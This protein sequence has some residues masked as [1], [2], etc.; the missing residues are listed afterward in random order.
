[1]GSLTHC[2][3]INELQKPIAKK[4]RTKQKEYL[5]DG[6]T[7]AQA[8]QKAVADI[9]KI[10]KS[11]RSDIIEQV[12]K[13][14]EIDHPETLPREEH[15]GID[16][17]RKDLKEDIQQVDNQDKAAKVL[18]KLA[19]K[20]KKKIVFFKGSK[21]IKGSFDPTHPNT[22]F[23]NTATDK[24]MLFVFG[25]ELLHNLK[26]DD[27]ALYL[28]LFK[29]LFKHVN[30]F[31][32]FFEEENA[33]R[34]KKGL[35]VLTPVKMAEEF[36]ADFTGEQFTDEKFWQKLVEKD[37]TLFDKVATLFRKLFRQ[38][39]NTSGEYFRDI[40]TAQDALATVMKR[41]TDE[42][43]AEAK[44]VKLKEAHAAKKV[45]T[46]KLKKSQVAKKEKLKK[47][48]AIPVPLY[49]AKDLSE[50]YDSDISYK[51]NPPS[52]FVKALKMLKGRI[53]DARDVLVYKQNKGA[54]F[55]AMTKAAPTMNIDNLDKQSDKTY[56][57]VLAI[58]VVNHVDPGERNNVIKDIVNR[59]SDTG[60]VIIAAREWVGFEG[61][62]LAAQVTRAVGD[63]YIVEQIKGYGDVAVL[64]KKGK[65]TVDPLSK[66]FKED[67][68][69]IRY[70]TK[71]LGD[72]SPF[73]SQMKRFLADKLPGKGTGASM[74]QMLEKWAR[75]GQFKQ[76]ELD[77]S[78][79]QEWL[80][81]QDGKVTK[82]QVLDYLE[83]NQVT[84]EEV[85]L[86]DSL[87]DNPRVN[88]IQNLRDS[89][90]EERETLLAQSDKME[91]DTEYDH[92]EMRE[93][94]NRIGEINDEVRALDKE[95]GFLSDTS[96]PTKFS[97]WQLKNTP[98]KGENY[99]ELL[100]T[101]PR[102]KQDVNLDA[103]KVFK[104][105]Y[106]ELNDE[107]KEM[108]KTEMW[109]KTGAYKSNHYDE[110]NI[111]AHIRFNEHT[112]ADGNKVLFIEE[113]QS[114]WGQD[115]RKKGVGDGVT[116]KKDANGFFRA[117]DINNN[118]MELRTDDGVFIALNSEQAVRDALPK[119][120]GE[121]G[122]PNAPFIGSTPKWSMLAMKHA[123]RWAAENGFDKVAWTTGEQQ[124]ERYDLSKQIKELH[125]NPSTQILT[126]DDHTGNEVIKERNVTPE[127][128]D[129]YIGKEIATKMREE[130]GFG[131]EWFAGV[132]DH[133]T[134]TLSGLDLKVGGEGMKGFYDKILTKETQ[135]YIKKWGAKVEVI[136]AGTGTDQWGFDV[137]DKMRDSVMQG[138][139]LYST[140]DFD[141]VVK[142]VFQ[143][144]EDAEN[145]IGHR[146]INAFKLV[147]D[148]DR[149]EDLRQHLDNARTFMVDRYAPIDK[150]L[151]KT[152]YK[153]HRMLNNSGAVL[154]TFLKDG[155]LSWKDGALIVTTKDEGFAPWMKSLGEDGHKFLYWVAAKRAEKLSEKDRENWF[156]ED[157]RKVIL[158]E[159]E[160]R[161]MT[162][163]YEKWNEKLQAYNSNIVDIAQEA[164]LIGKEARERWMSHYYLPFYRV[165]ENE[166]TAA[167]FVNG[168]TSSKK[169][170]SSGIKTLK[171][172]EA[173]IGDPLHN[174]IHNWSH[175]IAESQRQMA[176]ASASEFMIDLG[177]AEEMTTGQLKKVLGVSSTYGVK[178]LTDDGKISW[179][180]FK[181]MTRTEVMEVVD[182]TPG[183]SL[184]EKQVINSVPDVR[185]AAYVMSFMRDGKPVYVKVEDPALYEALTQVNMKSVNNSLVGGLGFF[186][187][188]LTVGATFGSAFRVANF[189]R[190]TLHTAVVSRSFFPFVDSWKGLVQVW[191]RSP[192][193]IAFMASG[194]GCSQGYLNSAD[195]KAF[196][197][198][199]DKII[200]NEGKGSVN[201]I[202]NTV[203]KL[204]DFWEKVGHA[205]EMAARVQLYTNLTTTKDDIPGESHLTGAFEAKDL[206]D[207]G[208]T[209]NSEIVRVL[210]ATIPF[211]NARMQGLDRMG[212]GAKAD[213][214]GFLTKGAIIA[215]ASLAL[216]AAYRDDDRYKELEDWDKWQY[217][218]F[219]IGDKH[220]RI[221]KAFEVG[222]VFSTMFEA[223]AESMTDEEGFGYF[224]DMLK[225]T[226][227]NTFA[228]G[229]PTA[230]SPMAEVY[231]NKSFFT[232]R[233]IEP[234][235]MQGLKPGARFNPWESE[236]LK[237]VGKNL[238][239][240]PTKL[241][242][243]IRGY[244]ATIGMGLLATADVM[245]EFREDV[246]TPEKYFHEYAGL[247]RFV[248]TK[249]GSTKYA[250]RYYEFANAATET[251]NTINNYQRTG[252]M[253]LAR[254]MAKDNPS[255]EARKDYINLV[256]KYLSSIR[257]KEKSVWGNLSISREAK[258]TKL[259]S[260]RRKK[261]NVYKRAY[262]FTKK[263]FKK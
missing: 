235:W 75:K 128:L 132:Q 136:D 143:S 191:Q 183:T 55:G 100:L 238:N 162:K 178:G 66:R 169:Y 93:V 244:T 210:T 123:I 177:M 211:L 42:Q 227:L 185:K 116:I 5:D 105:D 139:P 190:D 72:Q 163:L 205:S 86:S 129:D 125:Y 192:D 68:D 97:Q 26:Q 49:S 199:I 53:P 229:F 222:A 63:Q 257:A 217:H 56:D 113:I 19:K 131:E 103:Q 174:L 213:P 150:H 171:G 161:K 108:I 159:V 3:S 12:N 146:I 223:G 232:G 204:L 220:C 194:G 69:D 145:T 164:G 79:V 48:K 151:G 198:S 156:T 215:A 122:V 109:D 46:E 60:S 144:P 172:G 76:D 188:L 228:I 15:P 81:D 140:R 67:S 34:K 255:Y 11:Q 54:E 157:K 95:E 153:L 197:R 154:D 29:V 258:R 135:K 38:I 43:K 45:Q 259:E 96:A 57:V 141:E 102:R 160:S 179:A 175:L 239:I 221:P 186:K 115:A 118:E 78:G 251:F 225:F 89:L 25:H 152:I 241:H 111:L 187:R 180:E 214:R 1:M 263:K 216:W 41:Y 233:D 189:L 261:N 250:T 166:D 262:T 133:D 73:Y 240:S 236:T 147:T 124:A 176:R 104:L 90:A 64:V 121:K 203:Y 138:Q 2:I 184:I 16:R 24:T 32:T 84:V 158:D 110:P 173:A 155:N 234:E 4:I 243:L 237:A 120:F 83:E 196:S 226:F 80:A 260:L 149:R 87:R 142:E 193:Y 27:H 119:S 212:R 245:M 13:Q 22:L 200:K 71:D 256:N 88:E 91:F 18:Q 40:N 10:S 127:K 218:H 74:S 201:F 117:Y 14:L 137:T 107:Q 114:D 52:L 126:A 9:I 130:I 207:F 94:N 36:F 39:G 182:T 28:D 242:T 167:E 248:K 58:D 7:G 112:D 181:D 21:T 99:R 253:D 35:K 101:L 195:P 208:L 20:F 30:N 247:D 17:I 165:L 65:E 209:G 50:K 82:Q 224:C 92:G 168:P 23:I 246:K 206:L 106:N 31:D 47:E 8:T 77:W 51:K 61:G 70:S 148:S 6:Y 231:A 219:W 170:I 252:D 254:Q 37:K 44:K 134:S 33:N 249:P 85:A 202:F 59:M 230:F 62:D 98:S